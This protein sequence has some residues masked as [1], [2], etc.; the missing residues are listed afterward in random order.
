MLK[1]EEA[2]PEVLQGILGFLKAIAPVQSE[3]KLSKS[4]A[5]PVIGQRN[6]S[7]SGQRVCVIAGETEA[8]SLAR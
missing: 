7:E 5:S 6:P 8:I 3:Q 2:L 1:A 4:L